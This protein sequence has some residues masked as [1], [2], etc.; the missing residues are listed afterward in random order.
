MASN[1][2]QMQNDKQKWVEDVLSS[3]DRIDKASSASLTDKLMA[4]ITL[5]NASKSEWVD[6][7]MNSTEGISRAVPEDMTEAVLSR[8]ESPR[9]FKISPAN[10]NS[11]IWKIAASVVFLLLVNGVS[12]YRYQSSIA[13][14]EKSHEMQSAASELGMGQASNDVGAVIFGN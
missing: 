5:T 3:I 2:K 4:R 13:K 10:D 1:L 14:V 8:L 12:I 7:V 6:E 11:L 9:Q